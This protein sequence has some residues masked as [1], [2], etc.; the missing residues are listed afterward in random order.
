M[1]NVFFSLI[2][3]TCTLNAYGHDYFFGF[4][5]TEYNDFSHRF[6]STLIFTLHD[7]ED[8][9]SK[10]GFLLTD[11]ETLNVDNPEIQ[12]LTNYINQHFILI[13]GSNKTDFKI[14]GLEKHLDGRILIYMQS[15]EIPFENEI[16][17][18][19][20]AIMNF[21]SAQM[22]KITYYHRDSTITAE[23]QSNERFKTLNI[24]N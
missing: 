22:N 11:L 13:L 2:I 3:F 7:L 18:R 1:K 5:E 21:Q 24:A 12:I 6:E 4:A 14:L 19:F 20:D 9:M 16:S 17:C 10:D 8:A 23:F 15:Q